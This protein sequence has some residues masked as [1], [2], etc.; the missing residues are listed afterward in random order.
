[1]EF[2]HNVQ[3]E[4]VYAPVENMTGSGTQYMMREFIRRAVFSDGTGEYR[5]PPEPGPN[6]TVRL[7]LRTARGNV[8]AAVLV[9]G[10]QRIQMSVTESDVLFD[11]Y[12]T[13]ITLGE[14]NIEYYFLVWSGEKYYYYNQIG[15]SEEHDPRHNLK[16][17]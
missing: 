15:V 8:F 10:T 6:E 12:E 11:Y 17:I 7:R 16:I 3:T 2:G 5:I 14:E 1:M 13:Q 9:T 4:Q